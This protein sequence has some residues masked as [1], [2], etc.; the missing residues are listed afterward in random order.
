LIDQ[1]NNLSV[2]LDPSGA[3][4]KDIQ[5]GLDVK[6]DATG[7][8][9]KDASAGNALDARCDGSSIQKVAGSLSVNLQEFGGLKVTAAGVGV[10]VDGVTVVIGADNILNGGY[11]A[12][13]PLQLP[14]GTSELSLQFSDHENRRNRADSESFR[15]GPWVT[16]SCGWIR[17]THANFRPYQIGLRWIV[18][19]S[20]P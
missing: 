2:K 1:N 14:T 9:F 16:G 7:V 4:K 11:R 3:L 8:I 18:L 20:L 19:E 6:T 17:C 5:L 13:F 12:M 10:S 15:D